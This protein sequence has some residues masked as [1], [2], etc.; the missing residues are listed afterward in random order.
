MP[1][2]WKNVMLCSRKENNV[3]KYVEKRGNIAMLE[4]GDRQS[5]G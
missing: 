1:E 3:E 2:G 4:R 5:I